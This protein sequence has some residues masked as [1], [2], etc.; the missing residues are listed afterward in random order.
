MDVSL[1]DPSGD[2]LSEGNNNDNTHDDNASLTCFVSINSAFN[3]EV[4]LEGICMEL[5][6]VVVSNRMSPRYES[7]KKSPLF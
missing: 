6:N 2:N 3:D 1:N 7:W 5:L 4:D